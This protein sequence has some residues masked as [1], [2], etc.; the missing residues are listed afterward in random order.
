MDLNKKM[1]ELARFAL[2][3]K[4]YDESRANEYYAIQKLYWKE[5]NKETKKTS[6]ASGKKEVKSFV[7]G[8][9]EATTRDI[10]SQIYKNSQKRLSKEVFNFIG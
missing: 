6:V 4:S 1:V 3:G 2:P 10:T 8:F 9:G 7:N 5:K